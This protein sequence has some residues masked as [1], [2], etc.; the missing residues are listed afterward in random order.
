MALKSAT[1]SIPNALTSCENKYREDNFSRAMY[2]L[3]AHEISQIKLTEPVPLSNHP[4]AVYLGSLTVGSER[5]MRS[6]LNLIASLLTDGECDAMTLDWSRLRYRHTAAVRTALKQKLAATTVNRMLV[7]LRRVL[8][9]AYQLDLIDMTDYNKAIALPS[10]KTSLGLRGRALSGEEISTLI[11]S[12]LVNPQPIDLRDAAVIAI[13]RIGGIRRQELARLVLADL[14]C[15]TGS[16]IVQR[17]KGEKQRIVYLTS[18]ALEIVEQWLTI[19]GSE[20]GALIC[21][22]NKAGKAELRHFADDGD[23]IYKLVKARA[24]KAGV[25]QFSPHDFRRTFCSNLFDANTDTFTVQQL[26]GHVSPLTTAKYDRRGE[27]TKR[28]AI[29]GLKLK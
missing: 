19:R 2:L 29:Q 26:A 22:V 25:K 14:D 20:P 4:A 6:A 21:P 17:G 18:E 7:A 27:V 9:E 8:L 1:F 5:A 24:I 15:T 23:G 11:T 28:K 10:L 3:P 13:L 16:L 12:C